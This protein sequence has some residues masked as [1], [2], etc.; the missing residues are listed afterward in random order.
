M[1]LLLAVA[2]NHID[3]LIKTFVWSAKCLISANGEKRIYLHT[4][5]N[6]QY[7]RV[8]SHFLA[9]KSG[10]SPAESVAMNLCTK[11]P[12]ADAFG[13]LCNY[14]DQNGYVV[15]EMY[16]SFIYFST[17]FVL[18]TDFNAI[19]YHIRLHSDKWQT[20]NYKIDL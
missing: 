10:A 2:S 14:G 16:F 7:F 9:P 1:Q 12:S 8:F 20:F 18:L 11:R 5:R 17:V 15:R 4:F 19:F 6:N 13:L 3:M